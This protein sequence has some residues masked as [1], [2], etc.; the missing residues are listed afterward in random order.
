MGID[1]NA[2]GIA[3]HMHRCACVIWMVVRIVCEGSS[4]SPFNTE[5]SSN[6]RSAINVVHFACSAKQ[7]NFKCYAPIQFTHS[8]IC[9]IKLPLHISYRNTRAHTH[10]AFWYGPIT[11]RNYKTH[12]LRTIYVFF[13]LYASDFFPFTSFF[14]FFFFSLKCSCWLWLFSTP[15]TLDTYLVHVQSA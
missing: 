6:A 15:T 13:P 12:S 2:C 3:S 8:I 14:V 1:D 4:S 5:L 11:F 10:T 7:F 9:S